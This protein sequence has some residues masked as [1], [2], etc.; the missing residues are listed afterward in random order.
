MS[1]SGENGG[2]QPETA[3]EEVM[4]EIEEAETRDPESDR[5][6]R[7]RGEAGDAT[8]PNTGAQEQSGHE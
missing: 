5:E 4:R 8:S 7:H 1:Q 2:K 3:L 6:R